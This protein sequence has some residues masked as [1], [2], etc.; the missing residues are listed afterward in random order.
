TTGFEIKFKA[1]PFGLRLFDIDNAWFSRVLAEYCKSVLTP[2]SQLPEFPQIHPYRLWICLCP[3]LALVF[4]WWWGIR[5]LK[6]TSVPPLMRY[7]TVNRRT[8]ATM[9]SALLLVVWAAALTALELTIPKL[10][11]TATTLNAARKYLVPAKCVDD[12]DAIVS[13]PTWKHQRL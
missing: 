2:E 1:L 11:I 4:G 10:E 6:P 13:L 5:R 7:G 3:T 8:V 9:F 12:F